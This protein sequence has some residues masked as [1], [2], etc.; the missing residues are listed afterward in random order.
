MATISHKKKRA[1]SSARRR[2]ASARI[3]NLKKAGAPAKL[4]LTVPPML[5][6]LVDNPF[7]AENWLFEVKWDGYRAI[8][9]CNKKKVSLISR[10]NK[11][12]NQKFYPIT[13][14]LEKLGL[15][16]VLDGEII[17]SNKEGISS[18]GDLQ[19]WRSEADGELLYYVFDLLWY[20]GRQ[21]YEVPL[22]Q[23]RELLKEILPVSPVIQL[24]QPFNAPGT[25]FYEIAKQM[26]LEGIIAKKADS[27]YI[28]G[29]RT[30]DWLKIKIAQRQEVV[31]GG[32]TRNEGSRKLFSSLLVGVFENG[33]L[34]YTG[35]I[36][37]GFTD[38]VQQELMQ[39][40]KPLAQKRCPFA[41]EPDYNKPSRFRPNPPKATAT[42]LKPEL[43]CE[44]SFAEITSDGVMRHPSFEG[45]RIDKKAGEVKAEKAKPTPKIVKESILHKEKII[46]RRK[47]GERKT[48]L[49]PG[50][51][52]QERNI[53]GHALKFTNLNKIY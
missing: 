49:N 16:A 38:K 9:I 41:V 24:S 32:F 45:M 37:T 20:D 30:K 18:F 3:A 34:H 19:N 33:E 52:Q 1:V 40:F 29:V 11:S 27:L 50:E 22:Q 25:S 51:K 35:K 46:T 2:K 44:V 36:G 15:H 42:W 21:L 26:N 23:R 17:I 8:A 12:F 39:Q 28:P 10:N 14:A 4:P 5:A 7:D 48:L 6:T 53:N 43:V 13:A 47:P 31:I